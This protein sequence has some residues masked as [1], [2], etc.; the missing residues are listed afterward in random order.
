MRLKLIKDKG[1][2][3]GFIRGEPT[4]TSI[5]KRKNVIAFKL[6]ILNYWLMVFF[7]DNN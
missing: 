1:D 3:G 2:Q 6:F 5:G 4:Y 7:M